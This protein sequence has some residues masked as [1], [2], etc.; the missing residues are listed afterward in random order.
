MGIVIRRAWALAAIIGVAA[1]CTGVLTRGFGA[2][3]A[4]ASGGATNPL[5]IK[6]QW[7]RDGST[8]RG[9]LSGSDSVSAH[10]YVSTRW[11][12]SC[13]TSGSPS[14]MCSS[15]TSDG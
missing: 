13:S 6:W 8:V 12:L 14:T 1:L 15:K 10:I 9:L 5:S 2:G 4:R 3:A 7:P 11:T